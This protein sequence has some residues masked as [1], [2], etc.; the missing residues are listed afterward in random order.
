MLRGIPIIVYHCVDLG[1]VHDVVLIG[2]V[3]HSLVPLFILH[4]IMINSGASST[5]Y[6]A[7]DSFPQGV[8]LSVFRYGFN[9]GTAVFGEV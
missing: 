5:T 2:A 4:S 9:S 8:H 1:V 7:I 3:E 6:C